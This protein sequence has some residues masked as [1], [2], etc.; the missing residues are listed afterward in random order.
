MKYYTYEEV[1]KA[2]NIEEKRLKKDYNMEISREIF[3]VFGFKCIYNFCLTEKGLT[4]VP[5]FIDQT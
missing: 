3:D 2:L 5:Q 1:E 4:T